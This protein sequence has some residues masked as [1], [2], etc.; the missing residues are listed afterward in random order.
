M[1]LSARWNIV[2]GDT[3]PEK[4]SVLEE[5]GYEYIDLN[6]SALEGIAGRVA[7]CV[8]RPFGASRDA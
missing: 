7:E 2:P 6:G 5:S 3:L 8:R 4:L 1:K